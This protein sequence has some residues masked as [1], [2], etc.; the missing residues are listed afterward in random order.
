MSLQVHT[1]LML[2]DPPKDLPPSEEQQKMKH[3]NSF[4]AAL[5]SVAS[6]QA[7]EEMRSRSNSLATPDAP[8]ER[9]YG[10]SGLRSSQ[11]DPG[12]GGGLP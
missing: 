7:R 9:S 3:E 2:T 5:A 10:L 6:G 8:Q 4:T 12:P 1:E 11:A